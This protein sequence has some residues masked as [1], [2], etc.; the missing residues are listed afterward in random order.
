MSCTLKTQWDSLTQKQWKENLQVL[1]V[2]SDVALDRAL[3]AIF[4][5]QPVLERVGEEAILDDGIGF[6]KFDAPVLNSIAKCLVYNGNI[7]QEQRAVARKRLP[8]YWKQLM[9]ISKK[10]HGWA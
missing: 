2:K 3:V 10:K 1:L 6:N 5:A 8:K 4:E 9:K 7:T